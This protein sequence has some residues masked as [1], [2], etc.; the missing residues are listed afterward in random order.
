MLRAAVADSDRVTSEDEALSA[1]R[2]GGRR[3]VL[4]PDVGDSPQVR[5]FGISTVSDAGVHY[6]TTIVHVNVVSEQLCHRLPVAAREVCDVALD[7]SACVVFRQS[8]P[9]LCFLKAAVR[10]VEFGHRGVE[11]FDVEEHLQRDPTLLV[12]T[13]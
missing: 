9:R 10:G 11:V 3:Y 8:R 13:M 1:G 2:N 6:A 12:E 5:D 4:Y 7:H